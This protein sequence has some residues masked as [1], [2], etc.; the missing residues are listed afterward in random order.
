[1]TPNANPVPAA[2]T[3]LTDAQIRAIHGANQAEPPTCSY[4]HW[5][6]GIPAMCWKSA[7]HHL[8]E[9]QW[10][11]MSHQ[12]AFGGDNGPWFD[13]DAPDE[14][15][16]LALLAPD[17]LRLPPVRPRLPRLVLNRVADD[18]A[19]VRQD[20]RLKDDFQKGGAM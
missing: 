1:M 16:I 8:R 18:I 5:R 11:Q 3:P 17:D 14:R 9:K 2:P 13:Y 7:S 15:L 20:A 4:W 12:D 6:N 10:S 19:Q